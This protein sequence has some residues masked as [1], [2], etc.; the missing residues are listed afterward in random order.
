MS[1]TCPT[2]GMHN[3]WH[4]VG[5]GSVRHCMQCGTLVTKSLNTVETRVPDL[6]HH[7]RQAQRAAWPW[8]KE[9]VDAIR[10]CLGEW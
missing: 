3:D 7:S 9:L 5:G 8:A 2:C 10:K 1:F 6:V 4:S